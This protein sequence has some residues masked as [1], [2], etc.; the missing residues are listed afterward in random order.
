MEASVEN[1]GGNRPEHAAYALEAG[2]YTR[3]LN[4]S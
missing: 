3:P 4:E 2:G 1:E